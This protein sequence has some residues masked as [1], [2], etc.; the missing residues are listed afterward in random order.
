MDLLVLQRLAEECPR[1][2]GVENHETLYIHYV[3][4]GR[5]DI[6]IV[7][8]LRDFGPLPPEAVLTD[9]QRLVEGSRDVR[10]D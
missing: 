4:L 5:K 3:V 10:A 7:C 1:R 9:S 6:A 2:E 8:A